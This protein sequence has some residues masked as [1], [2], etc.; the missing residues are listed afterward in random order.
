LS[1]AQD[2]R[3]VAFVRRER[4]DA[5]HE[6][7]EQRA[8]DPRRVPAPQRL[9]AAVGNRA[10]AQL[11]RAG[12]GVLPS[13]RVHPDVQATIDRRRGG[14]MPLDVAT[15]DRM[16]PLLGEGLG[17]VRV[18]T[19]PTAAGLARSVDARAF[20]TGRDIFFG[21]GEYRPGEASG[22]HLVAHELAHVVQ[23][24]GAPATGPLQVTEP[25]DVHEVAAD[26]VADELRR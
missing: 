11:A 9:A 19:D 5:D 1:L 26:A 24:R 15:R 14:G 23:Q 16:E 3:K 10:F 21:P 13:G 6:R 2:L 18:H 8:L 25:G 7:L 12:G 20:T 4:V 22:R 17:D